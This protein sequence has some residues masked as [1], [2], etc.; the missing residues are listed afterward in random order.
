M[1]VVIQCAATKNRTGRFK[2]ED[3]RDI[4]FVAD[5]TRDP[6]DKGKI[7]KRPDDLTGSGLSYREELVKY[8]RDHQSDPAGG[9]YGF[10]PAYKLYSPRYDP[11]IYTKLVERFGIQNVFILSAGWGLI[12]ADFLTPNYDITFRKGKCDELYKF[13]DKHDHYDDLSRLPVD[14]NGPI[15]FLGGKDYVPLF[16]RLTKGAKSERI[17]F[18]YYNGRSDNPPDA[19]GCSMRRFKSKNLRNWFYECAIALIRGNITI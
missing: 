3:G 11:H 7:Y 1:I 8:N 13:R 6:D 19:P 10:F 2:T 4:L 9:P 17:V 5:P 15:V 14:S 16:C 18:Y 12:D